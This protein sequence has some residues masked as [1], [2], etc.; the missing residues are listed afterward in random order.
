MSDVAE[1]IKDGSIILT[2][3]PFSNIGKQDV[4]KSAVDV[5]AT[6]YKMCNSSTLPSTQFST[7]G[8]SIIKPGIPKL[9]AHAVSD[10]VSICPVILHPTKQLSPQVHM[11]SDSLIKT[12]GFS[13][14]RSLITSQPQSRI[15]TSSLQRSIMESQ[16]VSPLIITP[17][18]H[19][20][21]TSNEAVPAK[22]VPIP[23][24]APTSHFSVINKPVSYDSIPEYTGIRQ[25]MISGAPPV[26]T[27]SDFARFPPKTY[28]HKSAVVNP[29]VI[30][31]P[32]TGNIEDSCINIPNSQHVFKPIISPRPSILRKR[33]ADGV[34]R[35]QKNLIPIL[36]KPDLEECHAD[37]LS[38]NRNG[39]SESGLQIES[40]MVPQ[41][42]EVVLP[43]ISALSRKSHI[44]VEISPRKKP[45]KQLLP[46][47]QDS[48]FKIVGDEMEYVDEKIIKNDKTE[49]YP[50]EDVNNCNDDLPD[51]DAE[52]EAE[53]DLDDNDMDVDDDCPA[54]DD[55]DENDDDDDF[56]ND[57]GD[58]FDFVKSDK[59]FY[60]E[61]KPSVNVNDEN[62]SLPIKNKRPTLLAGY[63]NPLKGQHSHHFQRYTDY[64]IKETK[65]QLAEMQQAKK[66]M[67]DSKSGWRVKNLIGQFDE[68]GKNEADIIV[69]M[70]EILDIFEDRVENLA[71]R[72]ELIELIKKNVQRS[73]VTKDQIEETTQQLTKIFE[74][75]T[76]IEDVVDKYCPKELKK[77]S[78]KVFSK[79]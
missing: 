61:V 36:T 45:R 54:D 25:S 53:D 5:P 1:Q 33:D 68:M 43:Q 50:E 56:G 63:K 2:A 15:V 21:H 77:K 23:S 38:Q 48:P 57:F 18:P 13:P 72:D 59:N 55:Y 39:Y 24:S 4:L 3:S 64:K 22:I 6:A 9:S 11:K 46:V 30:H 67:S 35:A 41:I 76:L 40:I 44:M 42:P 28:H 70:S 29:A 74:Y 60:E 52:D 10:D 17:T 32:I 8:N 58:G 16:N 12:I 31:G 71:K 14:S 66:W 19:V 78:P 51:G 47:N 26:Y 79:T 49:E 75:K 7:I 73:K 37:D 27:Q 62:S 34:L 69:E 20:I 65:K